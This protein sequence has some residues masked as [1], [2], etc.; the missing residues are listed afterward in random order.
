MALEVHREADEQSV[1]APAI[2]KVRHTQRIQWQRC[3][4]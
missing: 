1:V 2:G 4:H 3:G